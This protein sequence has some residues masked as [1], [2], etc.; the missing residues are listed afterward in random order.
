MPESQKHLQQKE[1]IRDIARSKGLI[2]EVEVP[3]WCWSEYHSRGICYYADIFTCT[4]RGATPTIIEV[5][6]HFGHSNR[7]QGRRDARRTQ[8]IKAMWGDNI[9]VQ[10]YT[11]EELKIAT[12]Q[13]IEE[14]LN[15]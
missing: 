14:D 15:L 3:F 7:Y 1:R 11:L 6:G 12:D 4:N 10:R 5:D 13:E 8:D 2:A 9:E